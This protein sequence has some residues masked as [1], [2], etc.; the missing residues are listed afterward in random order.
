[1]FM[2]K[3][4]LSAES[5]VQ[6]KGNAY[7]VQQFAN[8]Y[9]DGNLEQAISLIE[10]LIKKGSAKTVEPGVAKENKAI[11]NALTEETI[12]ALAVFIEQEEENAKDSKAEKKREGRLT[13]PEVEIEYPSHMEAIQAEERYIAELRL[14][15]TEVKSKNGRHLLVVY[16]I[17]DAEMNYINRT[18]TVDKVV[19]SSIGVVNTGVEKLT[20]AVDYTAKNVLTPITKVGAKGVGA[21][22]K[23]VT[24]T[25]A[26]TGATVITATKEGVTKTAKELREDTEVIKASRDLIDTKDAIKRKVSNIGGSGVNGGI[27]V[28]NRD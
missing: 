17:T 24:S 26:R 1:M 8:K 15:N 9:S 18:Y 22:F 7:T 20:G 6:V 4:E 13:Y 10:V 25:V 2:F 3:K 19:Q 16:D 14:K 11:N 23:T 12:S 5:V 27:R 28:V 21:L